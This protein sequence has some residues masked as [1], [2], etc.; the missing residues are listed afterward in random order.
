M[1]GAYVV[2]ENK[3]IT[4]GK[5]FIVMEN[6]VIRSTDS[7]PGGCVFHGSRLQ[8][9]VELRNSWDRSPQRTFPQRRSCP[10]VG[11]RLGR[12][13]S[14]CLP[15]SNRDLGDLK[16]S[17]FY[18]ICLWRPS[19]FGRREYASDGKDH[20]APVRRTWPSWQ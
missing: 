19:H 5:N 16:A 4:I 10:L 13:P 11:L 2:T 15:R 14:F 17:R 1:F 20:S 6:A 12:L 8:R 18:R 3:S 7:Q 9:G